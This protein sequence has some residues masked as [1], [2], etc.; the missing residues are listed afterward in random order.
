VL[1]DEVLGEC[2]AEF[3]DV[4]YESV[5]I[6]AAAAR[7]VLR[8]AA[9]DVIVGSNLHGDIVSDLTAALAG[10][11]GI[12]PSANLHLDGRHPSM[13]EPVHGSAPDI[14][15]RG[16]ANPIGA[17]LCLALM[18]DHLAQPDLARRVRDAVD[19]TCRAGILTPDVGGSAS[20]SEV[21]DAVVRFA[22]RASE[23]GQE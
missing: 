14:A 22:A 12:A 18:L 23:A 16:I 9:S 10:S 4:A 19:S 17:I 5:L 8:P 2:A 13:F 7:L 20:T 1:W 11:L 3:P 21:T 15:G 6:D